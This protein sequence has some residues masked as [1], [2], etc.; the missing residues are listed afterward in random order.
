[1]NV[2][3][4]AY[5]K[6]RRREGSKTYKVHLPPNVPADQFWPFTVYDVQTCSMLHT[7]STL[8]LSLQKE[9]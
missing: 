3:G 6:G 4:V 5:S 9:K 1:L 8:S 2:T 7:D